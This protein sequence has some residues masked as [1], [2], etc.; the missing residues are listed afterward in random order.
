MNQHNVGL[1]RIEP[2]ANA[3]GAL[4]PADD[5]SAD[6][7]VAQRGICKFLLAFADHDPNRVDR[8]M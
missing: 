3:V 2:G 6:I 4:D 8:R 7:A 1:N 5:Q